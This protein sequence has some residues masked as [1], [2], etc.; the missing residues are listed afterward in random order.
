MDVQERSAQVY[1]REVSALSHRMRDLGLYGLLDHLRDLHEPSQKPE[2]ECYRGIIVQ[3]G[4]A[5]GMECSGKHAA[6]ILRAERKWSTAFLIKA[7]AKQL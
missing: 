1:W 4:I 2:R 6:E 7:S 3:C 5:I